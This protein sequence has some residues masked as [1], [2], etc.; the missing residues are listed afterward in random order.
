MQARP[1]A[2]HD[3]LNRSL[4]HAQPVKPEPP[5]DEPDLSGVGMPHSTSIQG[6][7][8]KVL[9]RTLSKDCAFS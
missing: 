1:E 7:R 8:F 4:R 6:L 9:Q 3:L 5:I 2:V